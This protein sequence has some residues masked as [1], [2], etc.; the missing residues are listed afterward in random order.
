M[1]NQIQIQDKEYIK[2]FFIP[3]FW[4]EANKALHSYLP[5][6]SNIVEDLSFGIPKYYGIFAH[7]YGDDLYY[8]VFNSTHMFLVHDNKGEIDYIVDEILN[9]AGDAVS[10]FFKDLKYDTFE[11]D[12]D[13][14]IFIGT[15]NDDAREGVH[16]LSV[17]FEEKEYE[18]TAIVSRD[19]S[20]TDQIRVFVE[21]Y[22]CMDMLA[23]AIEKKYKLKK[24]VIIT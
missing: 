2:I 11:D 10:K 23:N 7:R 18:I 6:E 17:M 8:S 4:G 24:E 13:A 19:E 15:G 16:K 12:E 21:C 5:I 3:G 1:S 9:V 20:N 14:I 22:A